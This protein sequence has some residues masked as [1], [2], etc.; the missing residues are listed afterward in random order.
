[1]SSPQFNPRDQY[2]GNPGSTA[3]TL[4]RL[5]CLLS[6]IAFVAITVWALTLAIPIWISP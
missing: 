3:S 2:G 6:G 1:M 4:W 5:L